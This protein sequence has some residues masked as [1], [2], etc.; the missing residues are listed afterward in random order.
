MQIFRL[1]ILDDI[2]NNECIRQILVNRQRV[3][4]V[5]NLLFAVKGYGIIVE[6][7]ALSESLSKVIFSDYCHALVAADK[8]RGGYIAR[9]ADEAYQ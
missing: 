6:A 1:R 4:E 9:F 2:I 5:K 3:A 8:C 7:V